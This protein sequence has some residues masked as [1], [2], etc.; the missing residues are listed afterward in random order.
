M[1]NLSEEE[2]KIRVEHNRQVWEQIKEYL[3][4]KTGNKGNSILIDL[5][6][7]KYHA[8]DN[9]DLFKCP[10]CK[11]HTNIIDEHHKDSSNLIDICRFCHLYGIHGHPFDSHPYYEK[12]PQLEKFVKEV[13]EY[14]LKFV[15]KADSNQ[16]IDFMAN[17]SKYEKEIYYIRILIGIWLYE[18]TLNTP[19]QYPKKDKDNVIAKA[20]KRKAQNQAKRIK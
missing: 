13:D 4:K 12:Y 16:Y 5:E 2:L 18:Y 15:F 7:D 9:K 14:K 17:Q 19:K 11:N 10:I 3:R 20:N 1:S 6:A 8:L